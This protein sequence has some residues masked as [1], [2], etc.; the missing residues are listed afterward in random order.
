MPSSF[1]L[2]LLRRLVPTG[3]LTLFI[4][5]IL[6]NFWELRMSYLSAVKIWLMGDHWDIPVMKD[7]AEKKMAT[8]TEDL[9]KSHS[10]DMDLLHLASFVRAVR[11]AHRHGWHA[12]LWKLLYDYGAELAPRLEFH[13]VF[14]VFVE[15][16]PG[17]DFARA[18]G[19]KT[20]R[21]RK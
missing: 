19:V 9:K 14:R 17:A 2:L 5:W 20:N 13:P 8:V 12:R 21:T 10:R 15:S 11:I 6:E 18:I 4:A 16:R 3:K 1:S 7:I